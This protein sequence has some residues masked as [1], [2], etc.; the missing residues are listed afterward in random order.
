MI[1]WRFYSLATKRIF[2]NIQQIVI[3]METLDKQ[4]NH[5]TTTL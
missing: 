5:K 3:I 4:K 1:K 2:A